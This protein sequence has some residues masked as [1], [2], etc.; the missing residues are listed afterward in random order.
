MVFCTYQRTVI[1][2][3]IVI[4]TTIIGVTTT[5]VSSQ[6][7]Q[8]EADVCDDTVEGS[9]DSGVS[10]P[11]SSSSLCQYDAHRCTIPSTIYESSSRSGKTAM[12]YVP[13]VMTRPQSSTTTTTS[14][15][16]CDTTLEHLN[17][18]HY[19]VA[20]WP[21][22]RSTIRHPPKQSQRRS[23]TTN[24]SVSVAPI[25]QVTINFVSCQETQ[26]A[27]LKSLKSTSSSTSY[28]SYLFSSKKKNDSTT[29][30]VSSH[31]KCC[32]R[33]Y[34]FKTDE[35]EID[36]WQTRPD[37]TYPSIRSAL[38]DGDHE[39]RGRFVISPTHKNHNDDD[40]SSSG[41]QYSNTTTVISS[42]SSS[43][44]FHTFA[45][46]STGALNGLGP[47]RW[48]LPP[49]G[50]PVIH[51]MIHS[52]SSSSSSSSKTTA[53]TT[54]ID[55]PILMSKTT[56]ASTKFYGSDY[57]GPSW[58][59]TKYR[60]PGQRSH[61]TTNPEPFEITKWEVIPETNHIQIEMDV[62][63]PRPSHPDTS[64][65]TAATTTTQMSSQQQQ[66]RRQRQILCPSSNSW[67]GFFTS[68]FVEPI[69]VCA[70]SILDFFHL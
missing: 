39:C 60:R 10:C 70:P 53:T 36:I 57:R 40:S 44:V 51:M 8:N 24:D 20:S 17:T 28:W 64:E 58:V 45:P 55:V 56:L 47:H 18:V 31:S 25:L 62:F 22:S 66:Q 49:Y 13:N 37:G 61:G 21:L 52:S 54:L 46:G 5:V 9:N 50:P 69:A 27:S 38:R 67:Y 59:S 42:S 68:L 1:G 15:F 35:I 7:Q 11:L 33:P 43:F 41:K 30:T 2:L 16:V 65:N 4:V 19:R 48:D 3:W 26:S 29:A 6:P 63:L 34:D 23:S 32:C 12:A 14:N